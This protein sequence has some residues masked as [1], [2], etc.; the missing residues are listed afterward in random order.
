MQLPSA[1][2]DAALA[3]VVE[4]ISQEADRLA[5]P[6]DDDEN[7]LLNHLPTEPTNPT[8]VWGFNTAYEDS[9]PTPALRD[10]RFERLCK[11]AKLAR[12]DDLQSSP[13]AAREWEF[14]AAVL[15]LHR[16]PMSW[17]LNW[18]GI[19]IG[20][21][22]ARLDLLFLVATAAFVVVLF[23]VGVLALSDLTD[24]KKEIWKWTS[25]LVG[26]CVYGTIITFLYFAVRRVEVWQRER[27][28]E[29]CRGDRSVCRSAYTHR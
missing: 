6:L 10:L 23:L 22:P 14:A 11:L 3:F 5:A 17:L 4:R 28:I 7:H 15:E 8:A 26:A 16:H 25:W 19:P 1:D 12:L 13:D 9:W 29:K 2:L 20:K 24:G 21:R 27:N 18:A